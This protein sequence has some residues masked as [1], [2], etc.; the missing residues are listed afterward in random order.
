MDID[1]SKAWTPLMRNP[2]PA[3]SRFVFPR[4]RGTDD[5]LYAAFNVPWRLG[6]TIVNLPHSR[7]CKYMAYMFCETP[8][9]RCH[10]PYKNGGCCPVVLRALAD[11]HDLS[12][13]NITALTRAQM[14][15]TTTTPPLLRTGHQP[16][17]AKTA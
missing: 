3:G 8:L 5:I 6:H 11:K 17:V 15:P 16:S 10:T 14:R 12:V 4:E 9:L 2:M 7:R 13:A 1:V